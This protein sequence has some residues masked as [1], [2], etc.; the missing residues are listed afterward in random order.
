LC[1]HAA[2][3]LGTTEKAL[4]EPVDEPAFDLPSFL[5]QWVN[6]G[7]DKEVE[8]PGNLTLNRR[9]LNGILNSILQTTRAAAAEINPFNPDSDPLAYQYWQDKQPDTLVQYGLSLYNQHTKGLHAQRHEWIS[10]Q[11]QDPKSI[12]ELGANDGRCSEFLSK[13]FASL[14]ELALVDQDDFLLLRAEERLSRQGSKRHKCYVSNLMYADPRWLQPRFREEWD[15]IILC[16]VIEH[17][18]PEQ[19]EMAVRNLGTQVRTKQIILTTPNRAWNPVL[20]EEVDKRHDDHQFE[21]TTTEAEEWCRSF[22]SRY[23]YTYKLD[24]I[25]RVLNNLGSPSIGIIFAKKG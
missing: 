8:F 1:A 21:W 19:L 5:Q 2:K 14:E 3:L 7:M 16:E 4:Y 9:V 6:T 13:Q 20:M 24:T 18:S 10:Q 25:G 11:L 22:C 12:L 17:L 23:N 15:A